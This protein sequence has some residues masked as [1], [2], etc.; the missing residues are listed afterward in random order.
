[1][2][3]PPSSKNV[4]GAVGAH[5]DFSAGI[6]A[7][8]P[9]GVKKLVRHDPHP[10]VNPTGSTLPPLLCSHT[11]IAPAGER[12]TSTQSARLRD[13]LRYLQA[14]PLLLFGTVTGGRYASASRRKACRRFSC[15]QCGSRNVCHEQCCALTLAARAAHAI[16]A[17]APACHTALR[18]DNHE[19]PC[20][21]P[22]RSVPPA[23][24]VAAARHPD[25]Y[26]LRRFACRSGVSSASAPARRVAGSLRSCAHADVYTSP[27][28]QP[29]PTA[30]RL[31]QRRARAW[32]PGR[33]GAVFARG[34]TPQPAR[35]PS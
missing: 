20:G 29:P 26:G 23:S 19:R 24:L 7:T 6:P 16:P 1:M 22:C 9:R 27:V 8:P 12:L 11:C 13:R 15:P 2:R 18:A 25:R 30:E 10:E 34:Y 4:V 35:P 3:S 14:S 21:R 32:Q 28:W 33:R 31:P 17:P 5:L